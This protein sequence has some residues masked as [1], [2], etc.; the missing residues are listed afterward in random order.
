M[1][2]AIPINKRLQMTEPLGER[3]TYQCDQADSVDAPDRSTRVIRDK[4]LFGRLVIPHCNSV[5]YY[6]GDLML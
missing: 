1:S 3:A 2:P 6:G 5:A 4:G